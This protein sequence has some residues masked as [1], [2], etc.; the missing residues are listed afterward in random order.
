M[1]LEDLATGAGS[2][3]PF[4]PSACVDGGVINGRMV[5]SASGN[6]RVRNSV[7]LWRY[8]LE[9]YDEEWRPEADETSDDMDE[10]RG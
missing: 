1:F 2:V 9:T 8:V 3:D 6:R 4:A 7:E 10:A 5:L